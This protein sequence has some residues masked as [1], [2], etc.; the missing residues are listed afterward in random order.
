M[1]DVI[2]LFYCFFKLIGRS[3]DIN[4]LMEKSKDISTTSYNLYKNARKANT[5][6]CSLY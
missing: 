6:C 5:R 1:E 2:I 4:R 3:E